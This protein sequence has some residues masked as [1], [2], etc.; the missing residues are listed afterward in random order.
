MA[1]PLSPE[2]IQNIIIAFNE[3][4]AKPKADT[5]QDFM[6]WMKDFASSSSDQ[7]PEIEV[8]PPQKTEQSHKQEPPQK[9]T[10]QHVNYFPRISVFSAD[11]KGDTTY[12]LWRY[13]VTCL[14]KENYLPE[15]IT[16]AVRK[17]LRG[18]AG[19]I[20][21][22]LGINASVE[23]IVAKMDSIYGIIDN[24]EILLA[25]F[26]SARQK[27]D[28]TVSDWSCRL[29][30]LLN[31]AIQKGEVNKKDANK[32]LCTMFYNGLRPALKDISGHKYDQI[33]NFDELRVA[34]RIIEQDHI[35][36]MSKPINKMHATTSKDTDMKELK[37]IVQQLAADVKSLKDKASRPQ[38]PSQPPFHRY[39]EDHYQR[40]QFQQQRRFQPT[41]PSNN[42]H[43]QPR[44]DITCWNCGQPGHI[45]V[46]CRVRTDHRK[47]PLNYR[48]PAQGG[49][50]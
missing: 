1:E 28:E 31:K 11:N 5:P 17:S 29:E 22:R 38:Q 44:Q 21:M 43:T 10:T 37:G 39:H 26:Y 33:H 45:A 27:E 40:Q 35:P 18:E 34:L 30:D 32:M 7:K 41:P 3:M 24:K 23:E 25:Q 46:G 50:M 16:Q 42:R 13:E 49:R 19:R 12:E 9:Y 8:H 47:K 2:E 15:V 48:G 36:V 4:D 6:Q 20:A 14:M